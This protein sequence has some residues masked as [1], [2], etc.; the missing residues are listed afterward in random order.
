MV[1]LLFAAITALAPSTAAAQGT[2][3]DDTTTQVRI[4]ARKLESGR[5]EFA[6]QTAN[7][8]NT[9]GDRLLPQ[10]RYL[11]TD[12]PT[13]RWLASS[14]ITIGTTTARIVA[15]KLESGRI[16]FALQTANTD[17]TWGDRL[18]PQT[19]YLPTDAPTDRWLT[20][21]PLEIRPTNT[22]TPPPTNDTDTTPISGSTG[23]NTESDCDSQIKA[24]LE[25]LYYAPY[26]L[27]LEELD[28]PPIHPK[29]VNLYRQWLDAM[30]WYEQT[31]IAAQKLCK[32]RT[33]AAHTLFWERILEGD[34]STNIWREL[35]DTLPSICQTY[36]YAWGNGSVYEP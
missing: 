28:L 26:G 22:E 36:F 19:R 7:T 27:P 2:T 17:N 4:V 34:T 13:D 3:S 21:S 16:E 14:P 11:P 5:I 31:E 25:A 1:A 24:N 33:E 18:L 20:S 6:L 23:T 8:D 35:G 9:W 32:E 12:A 15:R 10:T 29:C 30:V